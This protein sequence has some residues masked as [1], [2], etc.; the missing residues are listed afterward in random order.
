M[1]VGKILCAL[2]VATIR[3]I[4]GAGLT[5]AY[6]CSGAGNEVD[7]VAGDL[8]AAQHAVVRAPLL[9][10]DRVVTRRRVEPPAAALDVA[11]DGRVLGAEE[12][13]EI[14]VQARRGVAAL[15]EREAHVA[16]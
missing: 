4:G 15:V 11:L 1:V 3:P 10:D 6:G 8:L 5:R 14:A 16:D 13:P 2:I 12:I 7:R 9:E